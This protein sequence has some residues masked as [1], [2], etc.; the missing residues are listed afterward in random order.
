MS[1]T[2]IKCSLNKFCKNDYVKSKLNDITLNINKII[3]K[4]FLIA[5]LHIVQLLDEG[6]IIPEFNQGFFQ[7][8]I[9]LTSKLTTEKEKKCNDS[10]LQDTFDCYRQTH[11]KSYKVKNVCSETY[12]E[13][14][15]I[16]LNIQKA[17]G[18][19]PP[20]ERMQ[21]KIQCQS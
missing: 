10:K 7:N 16:T 5:N 21:R 13:S 19:I 2:S 6:A 14:D 3:F 17:L 18:N 8:A 11:P 1:S 15:L 4:T 9:A 12:E 20:Q